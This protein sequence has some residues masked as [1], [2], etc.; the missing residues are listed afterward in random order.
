MRLYGC[1][2]FFFGREMLKGTEILNHERKY[3][4]TR[5]LRLQIFL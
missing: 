1:V 5:S 2:P 4:P 3:D